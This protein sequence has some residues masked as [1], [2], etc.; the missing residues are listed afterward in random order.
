[1]L[2]KVMEWLA[3]KFVTR[4]VGVRSPDGALLGVQTWLYITD[5]VSLRLSGETLKSVGPFYLV[6]M[7][8]EV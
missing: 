7:P 8:W 5:C 1:M 4:P 2:F 6:S 3:R